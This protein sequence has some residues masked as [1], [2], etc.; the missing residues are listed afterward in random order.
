MKILEYKVNINSQIKTVYATTIDKKHFSEWTAIFAPHSYFEGS[1]EKGGILKYQ[2][3]D[4]EERIQGMINRIKQNIPNE[5]IF[6]QP[7]GIIENGVEIMSGEKVKNLDKTYEIYRFTKIGPKTE[8]KIIVSAL[9]KHEQ[10]FNETWPKALEKL[11][12]ICEK[13]LHSD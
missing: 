5:E 3:P 6:I 9:D 8:V 2:C 1:W 11:K 10:Y 12:A 13:Q 4:E 7:I